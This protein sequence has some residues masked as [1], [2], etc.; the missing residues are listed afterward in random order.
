MGQLCSVFQAEVYAILQCA[1]LDDL[2]HRNYTSIAICSD[3]QAALKALTAAK[4]TSA[5]VAE[6]VAALEEL[7]KFNSVRLVWVPGHSDISG[8]EEADRL[9]RLASITHFEGPEPVL[10]VSSTTVR[11]AV[12]LWSITE[13]RR[14]ETRIRM[15]TR[16]ANA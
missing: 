3:S 6:T 7:A 14:L 16:Q 11:N 8:N 2:R 10:G 12:K 9:A 5:L 13:Q 15:Q 4:I 1:L